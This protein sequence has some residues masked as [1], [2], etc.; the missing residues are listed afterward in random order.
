[1]KNGATRSRTTYRP[2][3]RPRGKL[4]NSRLNC[5][6]GISTDFQFARQ[7]CFGVVIAPV[8]CKGC[9]TR[10][11]IKLKGTAKAKNGYETGIKC[12][13]M[14]QKLADIMKAKAE[15][16]APKKH[17]DHY[18]GRGMHEAL[19]AAKADFMKGLEDGK[20]ENAG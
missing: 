5:Q 6:C 12:V 20:K 8:T 13:E 14:S 18:E 11:E 15:A 16:S 3:H 17:V 2:R 9:G 19:A 4:M 1:M 7:S 10:W